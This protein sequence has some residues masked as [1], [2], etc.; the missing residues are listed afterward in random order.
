MKTRT[1]TT[2]MMKN[3]AE[4]KHRKYVAICLKYQPLSIDEVRCLDSRENAL[5]LF[6]KLTVYFRLVTVFKM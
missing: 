2:S 3:D 6:F 1:M 5:L 4:A